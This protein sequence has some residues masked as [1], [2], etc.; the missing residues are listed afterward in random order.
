VTARM[1][2]VERLA[3]ELHQIEC[4][5]ACWGRTYNRTATESWAKITDVLRDGY[6]K[7]ARRLL[8]VMRGVGGT[9]GPEGT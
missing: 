2:A 4:E 7:R 1:S 9:A 5:D 3:M 6:R 8:Q